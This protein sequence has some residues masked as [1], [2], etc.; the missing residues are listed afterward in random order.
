MIRIIMSITRRDK[1]FRFIIKNKWSSFEQ[2]VQRKNI[3]KSIT[4][5]I[6]SFDDTINSKT[7]QYQ[8]AFKHSTFNKYNFFDKIIDLN[9]YVKY[10]DFMSS[11]LCWL[12]FK[13]YDAWK[14]ESCQKHFQKLLFDLIER[15][16]SKREKNKKTK[17]F[18]KFDV[19][20]AI[21]SIRR[22]LRLIIFFKQFIDST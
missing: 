18:S 8:N 11:I 5:R 13:I 10:H 20:N 2:I 22:L 16:I 19:S 14:V 21:A 15:W 6:Q 12:L 1:R 4:R 7:I 17:N 3:W 9:N